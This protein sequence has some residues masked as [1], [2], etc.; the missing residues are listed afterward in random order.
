MSIKKSLAWSL[1]EQ[2]GSKLVTLVVQVVLARLLSPE[3]FG[4][5]A[6]LLVITNIAGSLAQ[7]GLGAALIQEEKA[8][9]LAVTSA[10]WTSVAFAAVLYVIVFFGA[11]LLAAFYEIQSMGVYLRVLGVIV[12]VSSVNSIYRSYLQREMD[13]KGICEANML[14]SVLSGVAGILIAL[15]GGG[16]WAL[17]VQVL[18]QSAISLVASMPLVAWHPTF[19][20]NIKRAI[21]LFKYGWKIC[22]TGVLNV[23]YSGVSELVIGKSCSPVELGYYSQGRKYPDA[24]ISMVSNALQNVMFP[25]FASLKGDREALQA[26][27]KKTLVLGSFVIVPLSFFFTVVA[28]PVVEIV[29]T[30]KWLPS[31]AVFQFV[32]FSNC[33]IMIQI[34]NLRG[35]MAIGDSGLYLKLQIIKVAVGFVSICLTALI[36]KSI[37]LVAA[38]MCAFCFF[39][40]IVVDM[41]PARRLLCYGRREQ[42]KDIL[43]IY[44]LSAVASVAAYP[45]TYAAFSNGVQ[46]I[47][48]MV[49]FG[50][51]YIFGAKIAIIG[52]LNEF[53]R[54]AKMLLTRNKGL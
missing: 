12:F 48:Q 16:I 15:A 9:P 28:E 38:V 53:T 27:L 2:G 49:V 19:N 43:P 30:E 17:I 50:V 40:A 3:D 41:Q 31:V 36:T 45:L 29:L 37:T 39:A 46:I 8:E 24:I 7:S 13:F 11:P 34:V 35:Y 51:I 4:L 33:V 18:L 14:A 1:L 54:M 10:F 42:L 47:L 5:L 44:L 21:D 25:A 26:A 6:I 20:F 23:L 52:A 32:C 22:V